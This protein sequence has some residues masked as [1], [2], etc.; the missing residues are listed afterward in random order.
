MLAAIAVQQPPRA[1]DLSALAPE[2]RDS[3]IGLLRKAMGMVAA[4]D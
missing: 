2:E 3:M 1:R 4:R